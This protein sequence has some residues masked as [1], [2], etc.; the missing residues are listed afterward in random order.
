VVV[1]LAE[2]MT[3]VLLIET[4]RSLLLVF[5]FTHKSTQA[6]RTPC[7]WI[8]DGTFSMQYVHISDIY[9]D[10]RRRHARPSSWHGWIRWLVSVHVHAC[11]YSCMCHLVSVNACNILVDLI[12]ML[13]LRGGMPPQDM[14]R[15]QYGNGEEL[16][17]ADFFECNKAR[18]HV[19]NAEQATAL[20]Q[21]YLFVFGVRIYVWHKCLRVC[22][23][24]HHA[25][26]I[27][28]SVHLTNF[29][30]WYGRHAR[31]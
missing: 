24:S 16:H 3:E 11:I 2:A 4:T 18:W 5:N 14:R 29:G 30:A 7:S 27:E 15:P 31:K 12:A 10:N 19:Q 9:D 23:G 22:S 17:T 20:P 8:L 1:L 6:S 28:I 26:E 21:W 13:L 25:L